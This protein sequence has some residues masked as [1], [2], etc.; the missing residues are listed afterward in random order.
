LSNDKT[1]GLYLDHN[2]NIWITTYGGGINRFTGN[3]DTNKFTF[4]RYMSTANQNSLSADNTF[5]IIQDKEHTYWITT[6]NGLNTLIF[7]GNYTNPIFKNYVNDPTD[8]TTLNNNG[9]LHTYIDSK[10]TLWIA[11][12]DGFH[13][14]L[15]K[16]TF[17]RYGKEDG[18]SN[19]FVY[20]IL[21]DINLDLWLSTN[22][23]LFRFNPTTETFTNFTVNDG[24]QSSEFNLGAQF[25]DSPNST[26]YFGGVNGC[27]YF[28]PNEVD[29]LDMEGTLKF[30]SLKIKSEKISPVQ[31]PE[32]ISENITTTKSI[33]LNYDDFP[34]NLTF[35][36]L[37]FRGNKNNQ[38]VHKL[39][40]S[41]TTW[42]YLN[43]SQ[44]L[45]L[46]G[47]SKGEYTLQI[48]GQSRNNL[49]QKSPLELKIN[50]TPPWYK[51]NLAYLAYLLLFLGIVYA[52]YRI[53][54]Q[55]QIAGQ[56]S[57]RLQD[58]DTLKSR[59]ITNI[60]HE[61]RTPLTIILGYLNNLK[62]RFS[63]KDDVE[64][65]LNTIEQ[66][67]NNLLNLVNQML[68]LAKLEKGHL[69]I[70]LIQN[71]IVKFSSQVVESFV[72]IASDKQIEL[73]FSAEPVKIIMDYDA[74]KWRQ[75]L[76]NLISNAL[77]FSHQHC[78]LNINLKKL[79][80]KTLHIEVA[81]QGFGISEEELPFIFDRFYQ[82]EDAE[83]KVSQG[84]G[85]GL[86]LTK[87]LVELFKGTIKVESQL[88]KGSTF[89]ITLPITNNAEEKDS[90]FIEDQMTIGTV[91]PQLNDSISDNDSN[92]VLIVEDN[93]DM[94]R[95][96]ASCLKLD[97]KV[98]FAKDGKEGLEMAEQSIPDI[99][100]TDV[101]MPIMDGFEL[102]QKLQSNTNTNHIPIIMLTS[103]AMQ[104]DKIEGI[105]SGVDAYLTKPFQKEELRLRMQMLIAKR[106]KLQ[107]SYS[108][109]TVVEKTEL[110]KE[111]TD[112][113]LIFLNTVVD[114]IHQKLDDSNFGATELAKFMTMS[115]SQL[116]R[117]L[118][119]ISNT[120]TGIFIRKV[121]L[122][123]GKELLKTTDLSI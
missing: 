20:G 101:M 38:F 40:P 11:T 59:F 77:K 44:D 78:E 56:E 52:F 109:K 112:R 63:E 70:N 83:H 76:T 48:Q 15:Q 93:A 114:A 23:G 58:L 51:S 10:G 25:N 30:T 95:Y 67:S 35:S 72:S 99:V 26:L 50:V 69:N 43:A 90:S 68:D 98:S 85:V 75:V 110:K 97:Y 2:K 9:T 37:D 53:S 81:D 92:T 115:D 32:I 82:V 8:E 94:A 96:I 74:E 29:K 13:K 7:D 60:T 80:T 118:K 105:T 17:K 57:K 71:D 61:F 91:V 21:E 86:A 16:S 73:K 107:K 62:E 87:E 27:N 55:R 49:W 116:Y 34:A 18:L 31:Y 28:D 120:S 3:L 41:N 24:L 104:E 103:K 66:N 4:Q 19:S 119:A 84:T 5:N 12:Q 79:D 6:D 42:S 36:E 102:T 113:N 54:L 108:V 1:R 64:T 106:K 65:S 47:L 88:N 123:K 14:Y 45:Q 121:R 33:T 117:K 46:I 100:L 39:L 111:T 89:T 122:E 22:A